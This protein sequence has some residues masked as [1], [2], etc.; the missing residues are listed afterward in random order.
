MALTALAIENAK[1][2]GAPY[3]LTDGN[4]LHLLITPNGKK[5][6]RLRYRFGGKQNLLS[7]GPFPAISLASARSKRDAAQKLVAEGK[8]PSQ[9]K[10]LDRLAAAVAANN[11]F[12]GVAEEWLKGR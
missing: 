7:L 5:H 2:R 4:G 3:L 12:G 1:P 9:Q 11:T 6:W 10:K 8:D